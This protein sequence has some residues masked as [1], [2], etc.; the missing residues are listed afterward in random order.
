MGSKVYK[1]E[2]GGSE[3]KK[4]VRRGRKGGGKGRAE[5][6]LKMKVQRGGT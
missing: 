2:G 3:A 1:M 4:G 6:F 5:E